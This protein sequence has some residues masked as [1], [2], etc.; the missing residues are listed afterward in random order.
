ML[1]LYHTTGSSGM[2][3]NNHIKKSEIVRTELA[4][5]EKALILHE[6]KLGFLVED[7]QISPKMFNILFEQI[8]KNWIEFREK[9]A[10]LTYQLTIYE[11]TN[12]CLTENGNLIYERIIVG[13]GVA[14]TL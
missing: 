12:E 1:A 13:A 11:R 14:G 10:T 9:Y 5:I 6:C 7:N 3:A 4:Q 2:R 8:R